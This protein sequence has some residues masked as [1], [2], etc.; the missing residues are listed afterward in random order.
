MS[1]RLSESTISEKTDSEVLEKREPIAEVQDGARPSSWAELSSEF[2][3]RLFFELSVI[4]NE[5]DKFFLKVGQEAFALLP[6]RIRSVISGINS[7]YKTERNRLLGI[8]SDQ[9]TFDL[10]AERGDVP[11]WVL[12]V[13]MT[14]GLVTALW[15][16]AAPR[17]SS[18]L[19]NS[20]D[21]MNSIR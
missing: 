11:G 20:L 12:V 4:A 8:S 15:A 3:T 14:T 7:K 17:L 1:V 2:I 9:G 6:T 16:I 18:I 19:E 5:L 13:L 10:Q 21:S